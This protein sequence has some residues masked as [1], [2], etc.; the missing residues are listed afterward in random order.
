MRQKNQLLKVYT[1]EE[2]MMVQKYLLE[3]GR[4]MDFRLKVDLNLA[5]TCL[6]RSVNRRVAELADLF[7]IPQPE[8]GV[9]GKMVP[10]LFLLLRMGKVCKFNPFS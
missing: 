9:N 5:H 1:D 4:L 10:L 7:M 8:E 6:L 2:Y 3:R